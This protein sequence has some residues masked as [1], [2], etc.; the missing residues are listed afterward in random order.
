[1]LE[2]FRAAMPWVLLGLFLAVFFARS[3][4]RKHDDKQQGDYGTVGM[5][6]GMCIGTALG[7]TLWNNTGIG[8]SLGMLVGLTIGSFVKKEKDDDNA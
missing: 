1:M 7:S 2:F 6:I 8:I 4:N 5:C 3:A